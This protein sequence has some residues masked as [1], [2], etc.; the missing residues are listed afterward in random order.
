MKRELRVYMGR[1]GFMGMSRV[2]QTWT[3]GRV[4]QMQKRSLVYMGGGGASVRAVLASGGIVGGG[5]VSVG[6]GAPSPRV[7]TKPKP[8]KRLEEFSKAMA[9]KEMEFVEADAES[10]KPGEA[11]VRKNMME[12]ATEPNLAGAV[13]RNPPKAVDAVGD[14]APAKVVEAAIE[15]QTNPPTMAVQP[16]APKDESGEVPTVEVTTEELPKYT[17]FSKG[18]WGDGGVTMPELPLGEVASDEVGKKK[19]RKR[20]GR[21]A[22]E[23]TEVGETERAAIQAELEA[24]SDAAANGE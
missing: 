21:K 20:R 5:M 23:S 18:E 7:V 9:E 16:E 14:Y 6:G 17:G 11:E 3:G 2:A 15:P 4:G 12:M 24:A 1:D 8:K 13:D 19:H 10:E 22:K